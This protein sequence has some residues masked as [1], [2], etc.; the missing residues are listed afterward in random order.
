[1]I[2]G[3]CV[4]DPVEEENKEKI[5]MALKRRDTELHHNECKTECLY[6]FFLPVALN[7]GEGGRRN[8]LFITD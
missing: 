3:L 1:M 6:G 4:Q 2:G 7:F 8:M 5:K